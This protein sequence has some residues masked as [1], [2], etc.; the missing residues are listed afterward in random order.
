MPS[1]RTL[2]AT[3]PEALAPA[4]GP[5]IAMDRKLFIDGQWVDAIDA[6]RIEVN[7]PATGDRVA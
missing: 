1:V 4:E 7:D 5:V 6:R 3:I 2:C